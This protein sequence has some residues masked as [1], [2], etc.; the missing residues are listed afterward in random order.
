MNGM[1][2]HNLDAMFLY[3][4]TVGVVGL[5]MA[6]VILVI[7]LKGWAVR[8]EANRSVERHIRTV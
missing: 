1:I 8:K 7:A 4:V 3:T 5:L 2:H 6:W